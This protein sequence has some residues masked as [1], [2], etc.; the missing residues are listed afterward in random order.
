MSG[1]T[2]TR[3]AADQALPAKAIVALG[4]PRKGDPSRSAHLA[5]TG[6]PILIVQAIARPGGK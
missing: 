2:A 1:F 6:G 5:K 3:V 4:Y